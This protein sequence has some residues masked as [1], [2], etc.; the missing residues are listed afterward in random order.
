MDLSPP[1]ANTLRPAAEKIIAF[2]Q[3]EFGQR[4]YR[5]AVAEAES[6]PELAHEFYH[7]GPK[8]VQDRL[9]ECLQC[10]IQKGE[11]VIDDIPL[12]A[13]QFAQLC[14]AD[15]HDRLIFGTQPCCTP[16]DTA[17]VI[18][19]AVAMFMARYGVRV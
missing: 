2:M 9:S 12:A 19:G 4:I 8:L 15:L 6:F 10:A 16:Q 17:R 5:I 13:A 14:K 3:S 18:D 11:L 1:I 7:S